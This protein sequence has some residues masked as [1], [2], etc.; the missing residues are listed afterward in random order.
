MTT[1]SFIGLFVLIY[2]QNVGYQVLMPHFNITPKHDS[3]IVYPKTDRVQGDGKDEWPVA[4]TFP[5]N[6]IDYEYVE[7][8]KEYIT[9]SGATDGVPD[10]LIGSP[11]SPA[12]PHLSCCCS[13]L[14]PGGSGIQKEYQDP[15]LP[16]G[17]KKGAQI[18][19]T[20]GV[21]TA[22]VV[23]AEDPNGRIQT[24]VSMTTGTG[25]VG[26]VVSGTLGGSTKM[27]AFKPG[28]NVTFGNT[29][30]CVLQNNCPPMPEDHGPED[31]TAYY[32]MA[33][34]QNDC[35]GAPTTC[36]ECRDSAKH[37]TPCPAAVCTL[38]ILKKE[39]AKAMKMAH[40]P[41]PLP[42]PVQQMMTIDCSNSSYP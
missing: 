4:G 37:G 3:V 24:Q 8:K 14:R 33:V 28:A 21:A 29:P 6:G 40:P 1:V 2:T 7:V 19:V 17:S 27:I 10:Q 20:R 36:K 42:K 35:K 30:L 18:L 38:D 31:F 11:T 5:L 26:I 23:P 16:E 9:F 41:G 22:V 34:Q 32:K 15:D 25:P 13:A 12:P 39:K